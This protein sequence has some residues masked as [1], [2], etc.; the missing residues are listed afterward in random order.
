MIGKIEFC[1]RWLA[2][3]F[4]F[5]IFG[6]GGLLLPIIAL[7]ILYCIP[8]TAL[9]REGRA[10]A[11][12]HHVFRFYIGMMRRLGVL[13][14]EIHGRQKLEGAKLI[15]ANHPS[16]ID[17]VFLIAMVPN[18]NCV[19]KGRLAKNI[20]TRGPI[21]T[22]GYIVN[23][24]NEA[25]IGM[26]AEAFSKGHALIVFPEGTRSVPEQKLMLKRGAANIAI[27]TKADITPVLI[28][29]APSTLTKSDRWYQIPKTKVHFKI[30]VK[31]RIAVDS[32]LAGDPPSVAARKLTNDLTDYFNEEL[33]LND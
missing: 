13:S 24:N 30:Q 2:T 28:E 15:L 1:W 19:V 10:Q 31:D 14:Y 21:H 6:V 20:V 8:A 33:M 5:F 22:A 29:C 32:Y 9:V 12:I 23:D 4:S 11:L 18:A 26:A 25:V 7:P 27:R 17:V 16:L 3:A